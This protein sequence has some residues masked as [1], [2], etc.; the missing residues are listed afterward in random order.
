MC[1]YVSYR[2]PM[3]NPLIDVFPIVL[4][5]VK[6]KIKVFKGQLFT[7]IMRMK[8]NNMGQSFKILLG[9]E[10]VGKWD[11]ELEKLYSFDF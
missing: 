2:K 3:R 11:C 8:E 9:E 5:Q 7:K 6:L 4:Y 10:E 1:K